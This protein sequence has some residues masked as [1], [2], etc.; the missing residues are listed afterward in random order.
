LLL[1]LERKMDMNFRELREAVTN[2]QSV[3]EGVKLTL[4]TLAEKAEAA[5]GNEA[6]VTKLAADIRAIASDMGRAVEAH[7]D[8]DQTGEAGSGTSGTETG[9]TGGTET[10]E[11]GEG[12]EGDDASG[13]GGS[14]GSGR[15]SE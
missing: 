3:A 7:T 14:T 6:E 12:D 5:A 11:T 8:R 2:L 15:V 9:S 4:E 10:G 1:I 13:I